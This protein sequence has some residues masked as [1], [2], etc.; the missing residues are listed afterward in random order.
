MSESAGSL[1]SRRVLV[2]GATGFIGGRLAERLAREE[3]ANVTG[4]GRDLEKAGR[5]RAAGVDL[6]RVEVTDRDGL[7]SVMAG[8]EIVFHLVSAAACSSRDPAYFQRINVTAV[9]DVVREAAAAG[10]KRVVH[11]SS[12][13]AYGGARFPVMSEDR[14]LDT[15]QRAVYGRSKA[16]GEIR[17]RELAA[18]LGL[19]LVVIRPGMTFGPRGRS[20]TIN[21]FN[22]V[23]RRIPVIMGDGT[24]H[25]QPIYVDNLVDGFM[26]AATKR[27]AAGEAFNL[28]DRPLPWREFLGYYGRMCRR[29]PVAVPLWATG[30][31]LGLFK[32]ATGRTEPVAELR[33]FYLAQSIYPITKAEQ[34]LGYRPGISIEE[35]MERTEAWLREAG[36]LR[37]GSA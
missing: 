13:A 9:E 30:I 29:K 16:Q 28:V 17:A 26:L 2:T 11:T 5:V 20:W 33:R 23:K 36:Y 8:Q 1:R 27:V 15:E 24:G 7:R 12:M 21:L 35:G 22:L 4:T 32:V 37:T 31:V 3:G 25:A 10:V 6:R 14:P 19:E 18:A 34:L